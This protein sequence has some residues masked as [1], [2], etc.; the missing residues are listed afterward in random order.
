M[1]PPIKV[2]VYYH[3]YKH[4]INELKFAREICRL[5]GFTFEPV[6]AFYMPM[7]KILSNTFSEK[8]IDVI[9]QMY[10]NPENAFKLAEQLK[11][12]HKYDDCKL[13]RSQTV[14]N[15]DGSVAQCCSTYEAD[16][17]FESFLDKELDK[18]SLKEKKYQNPICKTCM[19]KNGHI[20]AEDSFR[21]NSHITLQHI[22]FR[23]NEYGP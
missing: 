13:R 14:I 1:K 19:S 3:V 12:I 21:N 23:H 4:N 17:I 15:F 22:Y 11:Q 9:E 6:L 8:D 10:M 20:Y 18:V 7:E 2:K 16:N 5:A